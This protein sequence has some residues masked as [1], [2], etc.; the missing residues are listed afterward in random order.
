MSNLG[1]IIVTTGF[2]KLSKCNKSPNLVTLVVSQPV[3]LLLQVARHRDSVAAISVTRFG[4]N[5]QIW[6]I[7]KLFGNLVQSSA[8]F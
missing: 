3:T 6:Q 4:E 2:E 1:K 7:I 8:K 5:S